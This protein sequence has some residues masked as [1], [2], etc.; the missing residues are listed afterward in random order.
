MWPLLVAPIM[1]FAT[2]SL[3]GPTYTTDPNQNAMVVRLLG[4]LA[5][6]VIAAAGSIATLRLLKS[7]T[8]EER[9]G[10]LAA[11][12]AS[13]VVFYFIGTKRERPNQTFQQLKRRQ[14]CAS[15]GSLTHRSSTFRR[16]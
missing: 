1:A 14:Y 3:S 4:L 5:W 11:G 10:V 16:F 15:S 12:I 7:T 8:K 9:R 6:T 13:V 2:I